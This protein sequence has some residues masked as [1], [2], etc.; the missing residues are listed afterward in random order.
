M[1]M[2]IVYMYMCMHVML[3]I[4]IIIIIAHDKNMS[5]SSA[6]LV[7]INVVSVVSGADHCG[8][9]PRDSGVIM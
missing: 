9:G 1:N 6:H 3:A 2:N 8:C 7:V 5:L 4:I